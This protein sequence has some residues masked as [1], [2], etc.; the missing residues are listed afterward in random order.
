MLQLLAGG[1]HVLFA[2]VMLF[3][4]RGG[5]GDATGT[6]VVAHALCVGFDGS[7]LLIGVVDVADVHLGDGAVV[8][9]VIASPVA[10]HEA[11]AE[12]AVAVGDAAVEADVGAPVAG[13]PPPKTS[14]PAPIA[15]RPEDADGR[16]ED[17]GARDPVIAVRP[18][19]PVARGPDIAGAGAEGL[20][21]IGERR[22]PDV[23]GDAHGHFGG[24][25][26]GGQGG[27]T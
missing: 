4:R 8:V 26:H 12:V 22:R 18:V 14:S 25:A 5:G 21:V 3:L 1:C 15:R 2:G 24:G 19:G 20:G 6:A 11:V 16:G 13:M 27:Y 7:R 23:D 10:A 9:V 17:P